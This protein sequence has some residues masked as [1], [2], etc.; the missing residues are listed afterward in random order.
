MKPLLS[1][2]FLPCSGMY[3]PVRANRHPL[4]TITGAQRASGQTHSRARSH[5]D[6]ADLRADR[7]TAYL[8]SCHPGAQ[9]PW[10]LIRSPSRRGRAVWAVSRSQL[11]RL[12]RHLTELDR[13]L[14]ELQREWSFGVQAAADARG[15]LAVEHDGKVAAL[16]RNLHGAPLATG[17]GHRVD[18][19][20]I[21]D[22]ASAIARVG[23]RVEDVALVAGL[24]AGL[25]GVLAADEDATVGI[26]ANP[27]LGVDLEVFVFF[28]RDE[29]GRGLGVLLVLGHDRA[30]IDREIGVAVTLPVIEVLA[31]EER[32]PALAELGLRRTGHG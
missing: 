25:L 27:E 1:E 32:N 10:Q 18:L 6:V 28:L 21:D 26:V 2:L 29:E 14:A 22:G 16:G 12:Y 11:Q 30:V 7:S 3:S 13:A 5:Q 19:G 20:V 24:G 23:P 8:V 15:L 4:T 17:L 9:R 31:V